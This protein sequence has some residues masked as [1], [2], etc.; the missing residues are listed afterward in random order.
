[1]NMVHDMQYI[2]EETAVHQILYCLAPPFEG[3]HVLEAGFGSGKFSTGYAMKGARVTGIDIDPQAMEYAR[4]VASALKILSAGSNYMWKVPNFLQEDVHKIR[5]PDNFFDL[6]FNEGVPQHFPQDE[7]RQLILNEM[8]RVCKQGGKVIVIGNDGDNP[9]EALND[10]SVKFTYEGM[11][12]QRRCFT[13][14][15]LMSKLSASG[16]VG[17]RIFDRSGILEQMSLILGYGT[18]K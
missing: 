1:M 2:V 13:R 7:E 14:E 10:K 16:L 4:R 9:A 15:E 6:V 12:P 18:K 5:F 11:G 3:M 17:V 8:T